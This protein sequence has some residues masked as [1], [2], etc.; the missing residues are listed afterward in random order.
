M[1]RIRARLR[2]RLE[3]ER[4]AAKLSQIDLGA[5]AGVTQGTISKLENQKLKRPGI[6]VLASLAWALNRCKRKV[7]AAD[8]QPKRQ[9]VLIQGLLAQSRK[10]KGAA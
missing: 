7:Q 9:P 3:R 2:T 1:P 5:L 6:D 8:L 10:R 4:R